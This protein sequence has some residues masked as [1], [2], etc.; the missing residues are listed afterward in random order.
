VLSGFDLSIG[1]AIFN[2]LRR[3]IV[4]YTPGYAISRVQIEGL[5]HRYDAPSFLREDGL[6]ILNNFKN[7]CCALQDMNVDHEIIS[8]SATGPCIVRAAILQSFPCLVANPRQELFSI[9]KAKEVKVDLLIE[10]GEG[11]RLDGNESQ[12]DDYVGVF[13]GL[14]VSCVFNP[15]IWAYSNII[16]KEAVCD[17]EIYMQ[18]NG[19]VNPQRV[20]SN[21]FAKLSDQLNMLSEGLLR[22]NITDFEQS[23][24]QLVSIADLGLTPRS[25]NCLVSQNINTLDELLRYSKKQLLSFPRL[26][27]SSLEDII[28]CLAGFGFELKEHENES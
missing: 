27:I 15:V 1:K 9:T 24:S 22:K 4:S 20:V 12:L 25:Y 2:G 17:I 18:T 23:Q 16:E 6:I 14:Q 3:I 8:F 19:T 10:K 11:Y 26:G 5:Q 7:V 13:N 21:A 28:K